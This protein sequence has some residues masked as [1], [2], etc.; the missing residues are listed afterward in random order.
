MWQAKFYVSRN[1]VESQG[2]TGC[3]SNA[4]FGLV[5]VDSLF[6]AG[7]FYKYKFY[8]VTLLLFNPVVSFKHWITLT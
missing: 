2:C 8:Y 1:L 7:A 4:W 6:Y 5:L 3:K